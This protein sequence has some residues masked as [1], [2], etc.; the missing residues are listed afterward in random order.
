[1]IM[2]SD[3]QP[4]KVTGYGVLLILVCFL[5]VIKSEVYYIGP[6]SSDQCIV[7]SDHC[8]T[9]SQFV[10]NSSNLLMN[11]TGL[12][13]S[14]G[15]HS[16]EADLVVQNIQ[17]FSMFVKPTLKSPRAIIICDNN[18]RFEF[19]NASVVTMRGF[20]FVGCLENY[21]VSVGQFKVENSRF[22]DQEIV[23]GTIMIIDDSAATLDTVT[24]AFISTLEKV[25]TFRETSKGCK[26]ATMDYRLIGILIR[27][28]VVNI[29]QSW[30]EGN[31]VGLGGVVYMKFSSELT[32]FNTT[33]MNNS[34]AE[35]CNSNTCCSTGGIVRVNRLQG[36]T[37][38]LY[39]SKFVQNTGVLVMISGDSMVYATYTNL[40]I[41]HSML[42]HN[43]G[44]IL[45]AKHTNISISYSNFFGNNGTGM[46][47]ITDG[48]I[49]SIEYSKFINNTGLILQA[50]NTSVSVNRSDYVLIKDQDH[51][52]VAPSEIVS[53][54]YHNKFIH[55]SGSWIFWLETWGPNMIS[56]AHN[57]FIDNTVTCSVVYFYGGKIT[58]RLSEFINNRA[59]NSVVEL[60]YTTAE[61]LANN[62]FID[63]RAAYEV[64]IRSFVCRPGYSISLSSSRCI[65]CSE[66]WH[67]NLV[68]IVIAALVAGIA[69]VFIMLALNMTVAVGTLNGIL[70][71]VLMFA[72]LQITMKLKPFTH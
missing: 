71:L 67:R 60:Q 62:V 1:M 52:F 20:D 19:R 33:F 5:N 56:I 43:T 54:F 23:H 39:H 35:Y 50:L 53:N 26:I 13:F 34:A 48:I 40:V 18:T 3:T 51:T 25:Q 69:L 9:L 63:N 46:V 21:V 8:L 14:P 2:D 11:D 4:P 68:G 31:N 37:V 41:S 36:N 57:E 15:N 30:F 28:S 32:I 17:S 44:Q 65:K 66:H 22:Y 70:V 16:L 49:T 27:K 47:S 42:I 64:Y 6:S 29:T 72:S 59:Y 45:E 38:K 12:V 7:E 10:H 24:I 58:L 55:N 61:T